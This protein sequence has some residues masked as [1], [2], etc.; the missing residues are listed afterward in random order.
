MTASASCRRVGEG[1]ELA[2]VVRLGRIEPRDVAVEAYY[3][4]LTAAREIQR[5]RAVALVGRQ[6]ELTPLRH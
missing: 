3:G 5:G 2:V 6:E 1:F 4:P